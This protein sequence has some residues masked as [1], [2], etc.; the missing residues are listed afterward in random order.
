M[1]TDA[2][3]GGSTDETRTSSDGPLD[4]AAR[5]QGR[6]TGQGAAWTAAIGTTG[7]SA[8][9][10]GVGLATGTLAARLLGPSGRGEL[11]AIQT[12][13]VLLAA[14]ALVGLPSAVTY[15]TAGSTARARGL[16]ASAVAVCMPVTA[17]L[18]GAGW[19]VLPPLLDHHGTEVTR[20]AQTYLLYVPIHVLIALSSGLLLGLSSFKAWNFLRSLPPIMWLGV[21][22]SYLPG[23]SPGAVRL[24]WTYLV[25]MAPLTIIVLGI[26]ATRAPSAPARP[27]KG[28]IVS[29]IRFG[30]PGALASIPLLVNLRIDQVVMSALVPA[31]QLGIYAAAVSWS[32]ALSPVLASTSPIVLPLMASSERSHDER[33]GTAAKATRV[34]LLVAALGSA[35]VFLASPLA[36]HLLFGKAFEGAVPVARVLA[37]AAGFNGLN[38]LL[39]EV[40]KGLGAPRWPMWAEFAS[41]PLTFLLLFLLLPSLG[42]LGAAWASLAAYAAASLVLFEG[43]R[44]TTGKGVVALTVPRTADFAGL[45]VVMKRFLRL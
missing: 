40:L 36:I 3:R 13:P 42:I 11:V 35:F 5:G 39:G 31:A 44:R 14:L 26:S 18:V 17:V 16:L 22:L 34:S 27:S 1:P 37:I 2:G 33:E 10:A 29:L 45:S 21:L 41:L 6:G 7:V 30:A 15:Y 25:A 38:G 8:L 32:G 43:V 9:L 12:V 4:R 23:V 20:A 24:S 28:D 19:L